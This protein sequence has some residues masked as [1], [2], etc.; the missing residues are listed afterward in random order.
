MTRSLLIAVAD[1]EP[2]ILEYYQGALRRLGHVVVA[3]AKSGSELIEQCRAARPELIITDIRMPDM[4]GIE[5]AVRICRDS[6]LPVILVSGY[7]E[8]DYIE[9]AQENH[10]LAYLVKPIEDSDL[11]TAIAIASSRFAEFQ[12]LRQEAADLRQAL[13]DR[14]IIEQAKGILM[15]QV[16]LDENEAFHRLRKLSMDQNRKLVEI[17]QMILTA[18]KAFAPPKN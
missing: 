4:D 13:A 7:H 2:D 15:K 11:A 12:A 16:G 5:A 9:R 3:A 1:D 14:K 18:E 10:V 8:A 6:P 17:A